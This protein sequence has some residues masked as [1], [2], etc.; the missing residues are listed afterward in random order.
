M[1]RLDDI[2]ER[3]SMPLSESDMRHRWTEEGRCAFLKFYQQM[4]ADAIHGKDLKSVANYLS[5]SRGLDVWGI[6]SGEL[7]QAALSVSAAVRAL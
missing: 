3:L 7:Y 1:A 6:S 2:I 5:V 4:R